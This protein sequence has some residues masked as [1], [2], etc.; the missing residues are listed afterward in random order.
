MI[1]QQ[2]DKTCKIKKLYQGNLNFNINNPIETLSF[3]ENED[4][5]KSILG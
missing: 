3:Y 2:Q 1:Y 4:I 5:Q